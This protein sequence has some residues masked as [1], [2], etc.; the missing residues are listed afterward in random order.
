MFTLLGI[1]LFTFLLIA[2][3]QSMRPARELPAPAPYELEEPVREP[4]DDEQVQPFGDTCV[5]VTVH[6][7]GLVGELEEAKKLLD[8]DDGTSSI[9][10]ADRWRDA[11][12]HRAVVGDEMTK[13]ADEHPQH[14]EEAGWWISFVLEQVEALA[15]LDGEEGRISSGTGG[16]AARGA[17]TAALEKAD[18]IVFAND[19]FARRLLDLDLEAWVKDNGDRDAVGRFKRAVRRHK[20]RA[21]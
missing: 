18:A 7:V 10:A 19:E 11:D 12:G 9:E 20:E 15:D 8:K 3:F 17:V 14:A 6:G 1:L 5:E 4:L 2:V 16:A 13:L 21:A